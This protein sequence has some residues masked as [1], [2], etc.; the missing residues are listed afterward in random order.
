[1]RKSWDAATPGSPNQTF[2]QQKMGS[3]SIH[4]ITNLHTM[5][6][7]N[8]QIWLSF[9]HNN[10]GHDHQQKLTAPEQIYPTC[11]ALPKYT[12][13]KLLHD[14]S[15]LPC[16]KDRLLSCGTRKL[17]RISKNALVEDSITFNR[18]NS[19]WDRFPTPISVNKSV[20]SVF[21]LL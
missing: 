9:D 10:I 4:H 8:F 16:V 21:R 19:T 1:M 14:L 2:S 3:Q 11:P 6:P 18:V 15:G 20:R 5:C 7:A 13:V 17:E 12:S